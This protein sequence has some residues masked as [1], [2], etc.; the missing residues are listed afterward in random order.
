MLDSQHSSQSVKKSSHNFQFYLNHWIQRTRSQLHKPHDTPKVHK[1]VESSIIDK[2]TIFKKKQ[3]MIDKDSKIKLALIKK[4]IT[5]PTL[6]PYEQ[7]QGCLSQLLI[8]FKAKFQE[9]PLKL[10]S[11]SLSKESISYIPSSQ[12][13]SCQDSL[14][15]WKKT[16][17]LSLTDHQ[18]PLSNIHI[19]YAH[20]SI[21]WQPI[22][23]KLISKGF[24]KNIAQRQALDVLIWVDLSITSKANLHSFIKHRLPRKWYGSH[25]YDIQSVQWSQQGVESKTLYQNRTLLHKDSPALYNRRHYQKKINQMIQQG[26]VWI[27]LHH[28][29]GKLAYENPRSHHRPSAHHINALVNTFT[30]HSPQSWPIYTWGI[31]AWDTQTFYLRQEST[32]LF[33]NPHYP[34]NTSTP[35]ALYISIFD[36]WSALTQ[37]IWQKLSRST[38]SLAT[39]INNRHLM[40]QSSIDQKIQHVHTWIQNTFTYTPL[41]RF[42]Y[43]PLSF[44]QIWRDKQGDCKDLSVVAHQLLHKMGVRSFFALTVQKKSDRPL[45]SMKVLPHAIAMIPSLGWFNHVILWTP[46]PQRLAYIKYYVYKHQKK[47]DQHIPQI[48]HTSIINPRSTSGSLIPLSFKSSQHNHWL[49]PTYFKSY[50]SPLASQW[51]WVILDDHHGFW[52]QI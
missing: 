37:W 7:I 4:Q 30:L 9:G 23:Q 24:T 29:L 2:S 6:S 19:L 50:P 28:P 27:K 48:P 32:W 47:I 15:D 21:Y 17:N 36:T 34:Y 1:A 39:V 14:T 44:K 41:N 46:T 10:F 8:P 43:T 25:I 49:D 40:E 12:I 42:P 26:F 18:S 13:S 35:H 38:F 20:E 16:L 22:E 11:P 45:K 31:S 51:A 33:H 3:S 5:L 52:L